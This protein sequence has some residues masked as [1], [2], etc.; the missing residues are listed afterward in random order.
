MKF[1]A[2][3]ILLFASAAA[4]AQVAAPAANP[5][6]EQFNRYT[7]DQWLYGSAEGSVATRQAF[8]ALTD[9]ALRAARHRPRWS[10]ILAQG[11]SPV[12]NGPA[13]F[14][15]CGAKPL[16]AVF[17]ADET[18]I[19]NIPPRRDNVL[20]NDGRFDPKVWNAW[21]RTGAG[22]ATPIPGAVEAFAALRRAGITPIVNTNRSLDNPEGTAATLKAAGL[23]SFVLGRN[24]FLQRA[25]EGKDG[26]RAL[27]ASRYCVIAMAGD[28]LG[29]FS[30]A[31]NAADLSPAQRRA[32]ATAGPASRLWGHG[33]FLLPNPSYGPWQG[34]LK[35][36]DVYGTGQWVPSKGA[37]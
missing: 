5:R 26:R 30:D 15:R 17:D 4:G 16:A 25:R 23:G 20:H 27:I 11:S 12:A 3:S 32:A 28:Q 8:G 18:L 2:F 31:F 37:Q 10:M 14:V 36:E 7:A 9:Y 29:D 19:W 1:V 34:K 24:L 6:V 35:F 13:S 33:W 21:E 22:Y